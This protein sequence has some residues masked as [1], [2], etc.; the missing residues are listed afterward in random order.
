MAD[1]RRSLRVSIPLLIAGL[2]LAACAAGPGHTQN[3]KIVGASYSVQDGTI[4]CDV[5]TRV[6]TVCDGLAT[7]TVQA[8]SRLC[9]MG[10]PAPKQPKQLTVEYACGEARMPRSEVPEGQALNL[11]C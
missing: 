8:Q 9:P 2:A 1:H 11:K 4:P 10:D 6:A 7:C 3:I 5:S